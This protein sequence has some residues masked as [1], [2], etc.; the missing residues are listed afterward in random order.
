M[1]L[2]QVKVKDLLVLLKDMDKVVD[3]WLTDLIIIEEPGS[4]GTML[5]KESFEGKKLPGHMGN[6]TV[7]VQ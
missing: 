1:L 2:V 6:V 7:T 5:S 3:L 4:L